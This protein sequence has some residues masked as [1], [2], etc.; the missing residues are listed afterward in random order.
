MNANFA[1]SIR[2]A[3]ARG[4]AEQAEIAAMNAKEDA[5]IAKAYAFQFAPDFKQGKY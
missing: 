1:L 5:D 2:T 4:K 3:T